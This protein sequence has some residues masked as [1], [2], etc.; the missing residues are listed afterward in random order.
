MRMGPPVLCAAAVGLR[1]VRFGRAETP[2]A[3]PVGVGVRV[4]LAAEICLAVQ[5]GSMAVSVEPVPE[6][7]LD[8]PV[9]TEWADGAVVLSVSGAVDYTTYPKLKTRLAQLDRRHH[10]HNIR[11]HR[12]RRNPAPLLLL[13]RATFRRTL[14]RSLLVRVDDVTGNT[15]PAGQFVPVLERPLA[16]LSSLTRA[17]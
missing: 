7:R 15:P 6:G 9:P 13:G 3:R 16:D 4:T 10:R 17:G 8:V 2:G 14:R 12:N 5:D 11:I 1:R